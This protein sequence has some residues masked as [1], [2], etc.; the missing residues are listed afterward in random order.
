MSPL[1]EFLQQVSPTLTFSE[2]EKVMNKGVGEG[3]SW[4]PA[5]WQSPRALSGTYLRR[6][7]VQGPGAR[8]K[9]IGLF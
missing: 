1:F 6:A 2:G 5:K 7:T 3:T 9:A 4:R 8:T